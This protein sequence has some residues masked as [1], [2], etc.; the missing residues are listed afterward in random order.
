MKKYTLPAG[1]YYIGDPC[2]VVPNKDWIPL[3]ERAGYFG[4]EPSLDCDEGFFFYKD[5]ACFAYLTAHG[6]GTYTDKSHNKY[7]VDAGV[8]GILPVEVCDFKELLYPCV[9]KKFEKDFVVWEES[10]VFHF[11]DI[12][13]STK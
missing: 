7:P 1:E 13:I 5:K 6:D 3:L 9:T 12:I 2:Y 10:G 4:S 11:G 8:I